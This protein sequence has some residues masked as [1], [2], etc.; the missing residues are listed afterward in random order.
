MIRKE[1]PSPEVARDCENRSSSERRKAK[2]HYLC[3]NANAFTSTVQSS[4]TSSIRVKSILNG[5]DQRCRK[6]GGSEGKRLVTWLFSPFSRARFWIDFF[7][8]R[9]FAEQRVSKSRG[10]R[11]I[12]WFLDL[13]M[14]ATKELSQHVEEN[15]VTV[16]VDEEEDEEYESEDEV[17]DDGE[18]DEDDDDD[19]DDDD[20]NE[21]EEDDDED[22][23]PDGGDDDDDEDEE[24][25]SDVQRGGEPDDDD[26]DDDD[27]DEDEE[28]EEE[29]GEEVV[30]SNLLC[31]FLF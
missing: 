5:Q 7:F 8:L 13:K 28:D 14:K 22:D 15:E 1:N 2:S 3:W 10:E 21:D 6:T 9:L 16:L 26:N 4:A 29:Q 17:V 27:E 23:A 24:E 12:L 31:F 11:N 25:E 18:D 19:D 30:I 20:D